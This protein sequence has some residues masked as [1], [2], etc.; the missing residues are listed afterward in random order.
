[1]NLRTSSVPGLVIAFAAAIIP[2]CG[3]SSSGSPNV[4]A[5]G[6]GGAAEAG[7]EP[8]TEGGPCYGN[9]TCNA[10]LTC[11]SN[12]C[13]NA[14]FGGS[15]GDAG[16]VEGGDEAG[17]FADACDDGCDGDAGAPDSGED[18]AES[19]AAPV[20]G[21][22]ACSTLEQCLN[23][24]FCVARLVEVTGGYSIDATE[25]TRAQ[26]AAWLATN[27]PAAGQD[28]QC[29]GNDF[30][31][32]TSGGLCTSAAW[33]PGTKGEHPVVCVDWCDAYAYCKAVDK[34]LCGGIG[35][36]PTA[37]GG[38]DFWDATKSQWYS[39]CSSGGQNEYPYGD[40]YGYVACNGGDTPTNT[41][42]PVGSLPDCQS[43]VVG[44][45]GVYDM[46]GNVW[47]WE[48]SCSDSTDTCY[49]RGGSFTDESLTVRCMSAWGSERNTRDNRTGFRCCSD[50]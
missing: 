46:S 40:A 15:G 38:T 42:A 35:G 28:P 10:G 34:R 3:S 36:G 18:S 41:T 43:S 37:F 6:A 45:A 4:S 25:V 8:G 31:P 19:D 17:G 39:A 26:Y 13:V 33:P 7:K 16:A 21:A 12:L 11:Y 44:Y 24:T 20:C 48:D 27:P 22:A 29:Q 50:P 49:I 23:G 9:G 2:A 14:G 5:A 1:M 47:E 32:S 30:T